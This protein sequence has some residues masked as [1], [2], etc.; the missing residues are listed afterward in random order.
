LNSDFEV[1]WNSDF[2]MD[3]DFDF[4]FDSDSDFD[5]NSNSLNIDP[6]TLSPTLLTEV[7]AFPDFEF[8]SD[9]NSDLEF[10]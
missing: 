4:H 6:T 7:S 9:F 3:Q 5:P 10:D 1:D 8:V 2:D